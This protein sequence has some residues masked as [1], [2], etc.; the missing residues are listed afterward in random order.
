MYKFLLAVL[1]VVTAVGIC[2]AGPATNEIRTLP[3]IILPDSSGKYFN[4]SD[5]CYPG[6]DKPGKPKSKLILDFMSLNCEP[7]KKELPDLLK[8]GRENKSKGVT[9]VVVFID[10]LSLNSEINDLIKKEN[11]DCTVL[12]DPYK[13]A[14][15]KLGLVINNQ[16]S[17]PRTFVFAETGELLAD[18]NGAQKDVGAKLTDIISKGDKSK[19]VIITNGNSISVEKSKAPGKPTSVPQTNTI[20]IGKDGGSESISIK[21]GSEL[22]VRLE[23][24][25]TTGYAWWLT[26]KPSGALQ[27]QGDD[28]ETEKPANPMP[29]A[30]SAVIYKFKAEKAGTISLKFEHKRIFEK[31][32]EPLAKAD[33]KVTVQ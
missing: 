8:Y 28:W 29:G 13:K 31:D 20:T 21:N 9:L 17:I 3:K 30:P 22:A 25:P 16:V 4:L 2:F 12:F 6:Q 11:I 5:V 7:C 18:I 32:K 27:Q 14:G 10:S 26:A 33:V 19:P 23:C 15:E 1:I 24:N